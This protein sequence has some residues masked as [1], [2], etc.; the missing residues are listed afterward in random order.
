MIEIQNRPA[1]CLPNTKAV[2]IRTKDSAFSA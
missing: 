2:T 1:F